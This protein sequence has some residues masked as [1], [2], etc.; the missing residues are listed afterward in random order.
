MW[1]QAWKWNAERP[2]RRSPHGLRG[3]PVLSLDLP[4]ARW[5][6]VETQLGSYRYIY[7][8]SLPEKHANVAGT[9]LNGD[10]RSIEWGLFLNVHFDG[11][12]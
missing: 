8:R 7:A 6:S 11:L 3:G 4:I 1:R 12:L 9:C 2:E 5:I 10:R